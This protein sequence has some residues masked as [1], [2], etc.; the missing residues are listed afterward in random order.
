MTMAEAVTQARQDLSITATED[1]IATLAVAYY[2][3]EARPEERARLAYEG[4]CEEVFEVLLEHATELTEAQIQALGLTEDQ[5]VRMAVRR[6][7]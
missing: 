7:G 1:D 3:A 2:V 5:A 4:A 6:R